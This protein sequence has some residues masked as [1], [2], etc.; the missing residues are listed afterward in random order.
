MR[1]TIVV[2]LVAGLILAAS[3]PAQATPVT[4]VG[5]DLG[6]I[7][8]THRSAQAVF[9][10]TATGMTVALTNLA[11][12]TN[13]LKGNEVT[14]GEDVLTGVF[15]NIAGS[16]GLTAITALVPQGSTI[17]N[18]THSSEG[19]YVI[20]N[21]GSK[22][23]VPID[24]DA[25]ANVRTQIA[26][27]NVT[28]EW[29]YSGAVNHL[30][31]QPVLSEGP[32]TVT[33]GISSSGLNGQGSFGGGDLFIGDD[34]H[35][36]VDLDHPVSPDG[37]NYGIAST[38][39]ELTNP[40]QEVGQVPLIEDTVIFTLTAGQVDVTKIQDVWFQYGTAYSEPD[41]T[42]LPGKEEPIPEPVTM[43]GVCLGLCA[44]AGYV[45]KRR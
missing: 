34:S 39:A 37:P 43:A 42:V 31:S 35:P 29:A 30:F 25:A 44:M 5:D 10:Q 4:F 13:P 27:G 20:N 28:G 15:F 36:R 41:F 21:N 11:T 23:Y 18:A 9:T 3:G 22:L 2:S 26:N 40:G 7:D 12:V 38:D 17:L 6:L 19:W 1:I 45:R 24:T 8:G 16:P 33:Y 32:V 14:G